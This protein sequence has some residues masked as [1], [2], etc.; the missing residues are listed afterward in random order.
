[1]EA[2]VSSMTGLSDDTGFLSSCTG[3]TRTSDFELVMVT[4]RDYVI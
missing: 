1:M 3:L 2:T 4:L